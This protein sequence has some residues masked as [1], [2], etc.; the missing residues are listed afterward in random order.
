MFEHCGQ[1]DEGQMPQ[2]GVYYKQVKNKIKDMKLVL[3]CYC[4]YSNE[5][6]ILG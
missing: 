5:A 1:T 4:K 2:H 6:E 3:A